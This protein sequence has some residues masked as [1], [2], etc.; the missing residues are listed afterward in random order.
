MT[1][2]VAVL[3]AAAESATVAGEGERAAR[4]LDEALELACGPGE[5][6]DV[7]CLRGRVAVLTGEQST[8]LALLRAEAGRLEPQDK[9][10]AARLLT[11]AAVLG[12][13]GRESGTVDIA[14]Q[15]YRLAASAD[16][17]VRTR[18]ATVLGVAYSFNGQPDLGRPYLRQSVDVIRLGGSP[19]DVVHLLHDVVIGLAGLENY[20]DA[21][22]LCRQYTVALRNVGANGVL[23]LALC[24]LANTAYF[25]ADF[26]VMEMA[27][28]EALTLARSQGQQPLETFAHAC[29]TLVLSIK[30][31]AG[32][33][34]RHADA[35]L[36]L[37]ESAGA[38]TFA[39][40]THLGLGLAE[41]G[42]GSWPE[43]VE[44]FALVRAALDG[45]PTV[46]GA[47]HWRAEEIEALWRADEHDAARRLHAAMIAGLASE[48]PWE[49][50]AAARVGALLADPE[51]AEALFAD[52]VR[53]H[54]QSPSAFERA[55]TELCWGEWLLE[56]GLDPDAAEHLR[57]AARTFTAVGAKPWASRTATLLAAAQAS[58]RAPAP[59][60]PQPDVAATGPV[61]LRAF[62][63][64]TLVRD[65]VESSVA[66]DI[67]GKVLRFLVAAGG[68]VHVEQ[69]ADALW[70]DAPP[71]QG[72]IRLRT[73]LSRTRA[74]YGPLLTRA[75]TVIR[76]ADGVT[77]DAHRFA[78]LA[79]AALAGRSEP[80]AVE[81]ARQAVA[82]YADELLPLERYSEWA[83]AARERL[84][85]RF[86]AL[87]DLLA[88][89]AARRGELAE[90]IGYARQ[91]ADNDPLD[92]EAYL[93]LA[94]LQLD[95]GRL[96]QARE[97]ITRARAAAA[98]L[99]LPPSR[100]LVALEERIATEQD[101]TGTT[102]HT[103][104]G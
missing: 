95:A 69:L 68:S 92:D 93:R 62:G 101:G 49:H 26:D 91:I 59:P 5:R 25:T 51:D 2:T 53:W 20:T 86:L 94:R 40:M 24:L 11:E 71:G 60:E 43:A 3:C 70:P 13:Y 27:A 23:P 46:S 38:R 9:T 77:V 1:A 44:H 12:L 78:E 33:A 41:L 97:T 30:G 14:A 67:P 89:D 100:D 96:R 104:A 102:R 37:I 10:L 29:L 35:A 52:A 103:G 75:G 15:A 65:G 36:G 85:Q 63:P 47:L 18:A 4:L 22:A 39:P 66:T 56:H 83:V 72:S 48:G 16:P 84:R 80:T 55:R 50:A 34:G 90:A 19:Q 6:T 7:L 17:L 28:T 98:E 42:G 74:R 88:S 79:R 54:E 73:V 87:L 45:L 64:L 76:W 8:V 21:L 61:A 57:Q 31:E 32:A 82:L 99:G 81:Q 58:G